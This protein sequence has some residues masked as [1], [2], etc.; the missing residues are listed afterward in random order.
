MSS[1]TAAGLVAYCKA[2]LGKPYWWGGFG[3]TA[4]QS[5]LDMLRNMYPAVYNSSLYSNAASQFGLRVHDCVGLIKGYLWSETPTSTP[6]YN[7][8]EDVNVPMLYNRCPE[9]GTISSI[10]EIPGVCVFMASMEHVGVYIGNGKVIEARGH[11]YGVVQTNL[12]DRGWGLWGK[13]KYINYTKT[14]EPSFTPK[15]GVDVSYW[16]GKDV[17]WKAA[18]AGGIDFA[19]IRAGYGKNN[20]DSTAENNAKRAA[21]AGVDIGFYWF[22][23]AAT[24]YE[25]KAE[26]DYLCNAIEQF[27]VKPTYPV[28]FDYE[29]DSEQKAPPKES[30]VDIARAFLARVKERGYYP[31]NYTNL[32]YLNRGFDKLTIEYDTWLAHWGVSAPGRE[33][34]IWQYTSTGRP[35]GF[36]GNADMNIA[37]K[38]YPAIIGGD[39]PEPEPTPTPTPTPTPEEKCMVETNL[40]KKGSE[41]STVRSW[42][43]LLNGWSEKLGIAAYNCGG[44]DGDF[45]P[46]TEAATK[47]FQKDYGLNPD[48]IVGSATWGMMLA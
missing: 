33:C 31:C 36:S 15:K 21:A 13:P 30:I 7:A 22:S 25:A 38:D 2:Q 28:C 24:A 32:D 39:T 11:A 16:N 47:A 42:Q 14:P 9:R 8:D 19:I 40:I 20:I 48:G 17:D 35:D 46:K 29:Y 18:K 27:G 4:S 6:V 3:Q 41:G 5:L 12:K 45:G 34:G 23:Y 44:A 43:F 10:P 26:A 1:K 37:Y